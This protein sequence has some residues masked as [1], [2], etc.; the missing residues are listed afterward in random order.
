[1][2]D[3]TRS[4]HCLNQIRF[5]L[6]NRPF[7]MLRRICR[8]P[9]DR[10]TTHYLIHLNDPGFRVM[11]GVKYR[12][13]ITSL[14]AYIDITCQKIFTFDLLLLT[15]RCIMDLVFMCISPRLRNVYRENNENPSWIVCG[16]WFF[17][18]SNFPRSNVWS[19][20]SHYALSML[21]SAEAIKEI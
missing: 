10:L 14:K 13:I 12:I 19:R 5:S 3:K 16:I 9:S 17:L 20:P 8:S 18:G 15:E 4:W 1:M 6:L 2:D 21:L 7:S 11:V